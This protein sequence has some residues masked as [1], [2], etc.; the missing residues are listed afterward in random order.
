MEFDLTHART[1]FVAVKGVVG[2]QGASVQV[3]GEDKAGVLDPVHHC[4]RL[5]LDPRRVV[6]EKVWEVPVEVEM[7]GIVPG[8]EKVRKRKRKR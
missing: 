3:G 5:W 7:V 8:R 6:L 4:P 2:D 1:S